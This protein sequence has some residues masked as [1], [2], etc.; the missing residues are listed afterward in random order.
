MVSISSQRRGAVLLAIAIG[1]VASSSSAQTP[2]G[3]FPSGFRDTPTEADIIATVQEDDFGGDKT[4]LLLKA[5]ELPVHSLRDTTIRLVSRKV[6]TLWQQIQKQ[7]EAD[8][9]SRHEGDEDTEFLK[10]LVEILKAQ[11]S[12]LGIDGLVT[13]VPY[14]AT[15]PDIVRMGDPAVDSLVK[16]ARRPELP[17]EVGHISGALDALEQMLEDR[18]IRA[19]LS[20]RSRALIRQVATERM[21][22]V[23][24]PETSWNTLAHASYLAVA[25]GDPQLRRDV[26]ALRG[27][28]V[29]LRRRG[30]VDTEKREWFRRVIGEALE[31]RFEN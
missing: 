6:T 21:T 14:Y 17:G 20:V 12:P 27:N 18:S 23:G 31:K 25:T 3:R 15:M 28:D 29:E 30:F 22:N 19:K 4:A 1:V 5:S 9:S 13:V 26:I 2:R 8:P 16:R 24:R 7:F 10:A 11:K